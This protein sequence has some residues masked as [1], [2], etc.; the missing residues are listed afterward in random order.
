MNRATM[1]AWLSRRTDAGWDDDDYNSVLTQATMTVAQLVVSVDPDYFLRL[2]T[3]NLEAGVPYYPRPV[4]SK[5]VDAV[6]YKDSTSGGYKPIERRTR[7]F[8]RA[9]YLS[10]GVSP[11]GEVVW[12]RYGRYIQIDPA[13]AANVTAG[14]KIHESFTPT[15]VDDDSEPYLPLDLHQAVVN[16]AHRLLLPET[17]D[18][19]TLA[20]SLD[21]EYAAMTSLWATGHFDTGQPVQLDVDD[22]GY[23]AEG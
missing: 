1:R 15:L 7:D 20:D 18:F 8:I 22:P 23:F 12:A 2:R 21:K 4:D 11:G 14:L 16:R 9:R 13:P 19:M 5:H 10:T 6:L 3:Q 17:A